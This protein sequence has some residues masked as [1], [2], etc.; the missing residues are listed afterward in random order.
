[1]CAVSEDQAD[2]RILAGSVSAAVVVPGSE[3]DGSPFQIHS[4]MPCDNSKGVILRLSLV[5][6]LW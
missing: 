6:D 2:G 1:M 5:C 3:E 4:A